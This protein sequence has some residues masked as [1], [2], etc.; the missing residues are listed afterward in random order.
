MLKSSPS[1]LR[2]V[3]P[4]VKGAVDRL[5]NLIN[6]SN[7]NMKNI[8]EQIKLV[9]RMNTGENRIYFNQGG[10]CTI[11]LSRG[12]SKLKQL[13][14]KA[15]AV[16]R[17][18]APPVDLTLEQRAANIGIPVD[19]PVDVSMN[20]V[21]NTR[22]EQPNYERIYTIVRKNFDLTPD[23]IYTELENREGKTGIIK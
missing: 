5:N 21:K 16:K 13:L 19:E 14:S 17:G 22:Y 3:P 7:P 23:Q 18:E 1:I 15:E 11:A 10:M 8:L 9:E 12:R 4:R 2:S 6:A 20:S